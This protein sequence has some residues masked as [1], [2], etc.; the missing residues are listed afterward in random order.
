[1]SA[2]KGSVVTYKLN[3]AGQVSAV[4]VPAAGV[5]D[6][7]F[8]TKPNTAATLAG[9]DEDRNSFVLNSGSKH[10]LSEN[11]VVFYVYG[12]ED[13]YEVVALNNLSDG[14]T[15]SNVDVYDIDEDRVMGAIVIKAQA[16][17]SPAVENA[18]FVTKTATT[19]DEEGYDVVR[20]TGYVGLE[21]VSYICEDGKEP[22][23][24]SLVVPV[25]A[26]N[27]DVDTFLPVTDSKVVD[28][29]EDIA[30][31]TGV[32]KVYKDDVWYSPIDSTKGYITVNGNEYKV[33][34]NAN[35]YVYDADKA[36][37]VKHVVDAGLDYVEFVVEEDTGANELYIDGEL[38]TSNVT[39][40][41]YQYDGDIVDVLYYIS[42]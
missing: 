18:T 21:E 30:G 1:M 9:Y 5:K 19:T 4:E 39:V 36:G 12:D 14:D 34:G 38:S 40:Y 3:A 28:K 6:D 25:Y 17:F 42:K 32:L 8:F 16:N 22:A 11:T 33:A 2:L 7:E 15:L 35:V 37:R 41:M 20:V 23:I 13:D 26:A 29:E 31:Y 24:G 27:G 10:Y